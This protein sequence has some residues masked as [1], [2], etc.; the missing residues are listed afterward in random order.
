[1]TLVL[2]FVVYVAE[3][4]Q[5]DCEGGEGVTSIL[6]PGEPC[7]DKVVRTFGQSLWLV[8]TTMF[9]V[10][11]QYQCSPNVVSVEPKCANAPMH[12]CTNAPTRQCANAP[13]QPMPQVSF[14]RCVPTTHLARGMCLLAVF[15]G[16]LITSS[17][18]AVVS[19]AG[20]PSAFTRYS[21]QHLAERHA[22]RGH[23]D[24]AA[25]YMQRHWRTRAAGRGAPATTPRSRTSR[26][27][28]W[29]E[30]RFGERAARQE[31]RQ[32]RVIE[33]GCVQERLADEARTA[34]CNH[35]HIIIGAQPATMC[36]H[37]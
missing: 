23:A 15:A 30:L 14:G 24:S 27:A 18:V 33:Q 5:E 28:A 2:A 36:R 16:M 6:S 31:M 10:P 34:A 20:N 32:K 3:A 7:S 19:R 4:W 8:T 21:M 22:R 29:D 1:M 35:D 12:P 9:Q 13:M 26:A 11:M 37:P 25:T 17:L